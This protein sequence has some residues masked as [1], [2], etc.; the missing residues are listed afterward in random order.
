MEKYS[1]TKVIKML[2]KTNS[3][4][5]PIPTIK[6]L[7]YVLGYSWVYLCYLNCKVTIRMILLSLSRLVNRFGYQTVNVVGLINE[8]AIGSCVSHLF[9][10]PENSR[11]FSMPRN[12]RVTCNVV[13]SPITEREETQC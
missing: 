5:C 7:T 12:F 11:F 9:S 13:V 3:H 10:A 1:K 6:H 2:G 4:D 8:I